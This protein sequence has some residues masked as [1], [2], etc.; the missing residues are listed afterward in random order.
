[1]DTPEMLFENGT[2]IG[3]NFSWVDTE[4]MS[5][6]VQTN[7]QDDVDV[8]RTTVRG[9]NNLGQLLQFTLYIN[10]S[11][12]SAPEFA[13]TIQTYF[14][15]GIDEI[16]T[17]ALPYFFDPENNDVADLYLSAMP[18]FTYPEFVTFNN[19]SLTP[20]FTIAPTQNKYK[21]TKHYF[22][23]VL[24]ERNSDFMKNIEYIT[25]NVTGIPDVVVDPN[26][27]QPVDE[28][29]NNATN[30]TNGTDPEVNKTQIIMKLDEI[31]TN[32]TGVLRFSEPV[33]TQ[34]MLDRT[35][36]NS[37]FKVYVQNINK[38]IL[39]LEDF[40]ILGVENDTNY[41]F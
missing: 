37:M 18:G 39:E 41:H 22:A 21:G 32:S 24:K 16:T 23:V 30:N 1:M 29:N 31:M 8:H 19:D 25:V 20:A 40:E 33:K 36:F 3:T 13:E 5:I 28:N 26:T 34:L 38:E 12:N 2:V 10:V 27:G 4:S 9:C 6:F 17:Y 35:T 14:N 11:T 15:I 7:N